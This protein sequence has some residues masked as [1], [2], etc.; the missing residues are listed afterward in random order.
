MSSGLVDWADDPTFSTALRQMHGKLMRGRYAGWWTL[1]VAWFNRDQPTGDGAVY[2]ILFNRP[3]DEFC[4]LTLAACDGD[5]DIA[6]PMIV[7]E[8]G[9]YVVFI[10]TRGLPL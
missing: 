9:G 4:Q 3:D 5:L 2:A 8:Y 1:E 10:P 7:Q 6:A